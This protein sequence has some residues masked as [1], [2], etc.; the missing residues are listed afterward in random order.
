[1][2]L[3][4]VIPKIGGTKNFNFKKIRELE[5]DLIIG[6]KEENYKEGIDLLKKEYPV[7]LSDIQTVPDALSLIIELGQLLGRKK[8]A[9]ELYQKL[10][11][12]Y[13]SIRNTKKGSVV[14]VIWK[15]PLLTAGSDTYINSMLEWV[16][17]ENI[18]KDLRYP[19]KTFE[20]IQELKPEKILL[21]SE[22]FPFKENDKTFFKNKTKVE[23][24]ELVN[25]EFYSWY[26][27]RVS[28]VFTDIYPY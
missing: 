17:Y 9:D 15:E 2:I 12:S 16:G 5:P 4:S 23:E 1:M 7:W 18:I 21:S 10:S 24:V 22:P 14:Y 6:N 25:G 28:K 3:F 8:E 26:G 20:D 19:K 13:E 11:N 27:S